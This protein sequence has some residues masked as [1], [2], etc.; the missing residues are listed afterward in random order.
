MTTNRSKQTEE[1]VDNRRR[2]LEFTV[3]DHVFLK[4]SPM[5]GLM[6]FR[7]KGKLALRFI[8]PFE[9]LDRVGVVA[10]RLALPTAL[11]K[12][13][14]EQVLRTKTISVVKILKSDHGEEE[15]TWERE[16]EVM[17]KYPHL[18]G[19]TPQDGTPSHH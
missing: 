12:I 5:K 16:A 15:A 4:I 2:D 13:H 18:F 6:R 17:E 10:Y 7:Q 8:G 1:F 3:G 19:D 11:A 14:N 9:I